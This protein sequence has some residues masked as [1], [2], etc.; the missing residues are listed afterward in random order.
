VDGVRGQDR[1]AQLLRECP[2]GAR[3]GCRAA[4]A[5]DGRARSGA[6]ATRRGA[7]GT[8]DRP[9]TE[10]TSDCTADHERDPDVHR[11]PVDPAHQPAVD[12]GERLQRVDLAGLVTLLDAGEIRHLRVGG[13]V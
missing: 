4:A 10:R 12:R 3:T 7:P 2:A 5:A 1:D 9:E 13:V 6:D 11:V 8:T